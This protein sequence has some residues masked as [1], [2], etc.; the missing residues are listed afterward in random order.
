MATHSFLWTLLIRKFPLRTRTKKP[1]TMPDR[2]EVKYSSHFINPDDF[3]FA[4]SLSQF[5]LPLTFSLF[6]FST[7]F[8]W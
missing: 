6:A 8:R 2:K 7:N 4:F 3:R 1:L 5:K